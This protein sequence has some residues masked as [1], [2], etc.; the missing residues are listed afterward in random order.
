[1]F[2]YCGLSSIYWCL[3]NNR[4][5]RW[6]YSSRSALFLQT[7]SRWCYIIFP[8]LVN[9][10]KNRIW[11]F[12]C[13]SIKSERRGDP[14]SPYT[15]KQVGWPRGKRQGFAEKKW[16]RGVRFWCW[17]FVKKEMG[18]LKNLQCLRHSTNRG[19]GNERGEKRA[20]SPPSHFYW[21]RPLQWV[22]QRHRNKHSLICS[23]TNAR[24]VKRRSSTRKETRIREKTRRRERSA[25]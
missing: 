5:L 12:H 1:M 3:I 9:Y 14:T 24:K 16:K 13:D 19:F 6:F 21:N 18:C 17:Y 20:K 2:E 25:G 22:W 11:T 10:L 7:T 8:L 4:I 23:Q 15:L